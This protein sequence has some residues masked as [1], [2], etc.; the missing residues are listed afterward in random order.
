V[1]EFAAGAVWVPLG[2]K[3]VDYMASTPTAG[4]S[5]LVS[6]RLGNSKKFIIFQL[7]VPRVF[8]ENFSVKILK[9]SAGITID[10]CGGA[11]WQKGGGGVA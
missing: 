4:G 11:F 7:R 2:T 9:L 6:L 3:L 1:K 8:L 10:I 5:N